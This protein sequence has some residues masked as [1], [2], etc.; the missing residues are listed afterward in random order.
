MLMRIGCT[1]AEEIMARPRFR[2]CSASSLSVSVVSQFGL[3][4]G[5]SRIEFLK[6]D[7]ATGEW[8]D[9]DED[10]NSVAVVV[11]LCV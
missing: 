10:E 4:I 6:S 3:M 9:R 2:A 11:A 5:G 8:G 7:I 1:A